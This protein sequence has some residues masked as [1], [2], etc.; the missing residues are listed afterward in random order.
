MDVFIT[1][2]MNARRRHVYTIMQLVYLNQNNIVNLI[3]HLFI[4][5]ISSD[6]HFSIINSNINKGGVGYCLR[7]HYES[8]AH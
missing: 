2:S 5:Q 6:I 3:F 7:S 8:R 4:Q 1:N